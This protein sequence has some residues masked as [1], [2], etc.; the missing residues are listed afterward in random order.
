MSVCVLPILLLLATFESETFFNWA[1]YSHPTYDHETSFYFTSHSDKPLQCYPLDFHTI[2]QKV[3]RDN[4]HRR[5]E[6]KSI[7]RDF[8]R[9][10]SLIPI[11][12]FLFKRM[13]KSLGEKVFFSGVNI[14]FNFVMMKT[15]QSYRREDRLSL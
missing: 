9:I 11:R 3:R 4:T 8:S 12:I 14:S 13:R 10:N 5:E 6:S 7:Y 15:I 2:F 1:L